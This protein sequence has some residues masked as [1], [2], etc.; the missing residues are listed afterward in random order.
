[1]VY[2]PLTFPPSIIS[3]KLTGF[4]LPAVTGPDH[5]IVMKMRE[6]REEVQ[7]RAMSSE[8]TKRHVKRLLKVQEDAYRAQ[9][10]SPNPGMPYKFCSWECLKLY[11]V[12]NCQK[13]YIFQFQTMID[14]AAG[15]IVL[16]EP[17]P[18]PQTRA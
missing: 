15:Y 10:R 14:L 17:P 3:Q 1:M 18:L 13:R 8:N 4:C 16:Q 2:L 12:K 5:A 6:V 7:R 11:T 9:G